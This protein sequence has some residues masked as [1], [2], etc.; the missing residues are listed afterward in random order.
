MAKKINIERLRQGK[1]HERN[2]IR[3]GTCDVNDKMG[4]R[5]ENNKMNEITER[6]LS[7]NYRNQ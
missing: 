7:G 5:G 1:D 6:R 3:L 2:M 4:R